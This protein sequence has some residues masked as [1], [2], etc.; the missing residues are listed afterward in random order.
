[1]DT[2]IN[3]LNELKEISPY[4]AGIERRNVYVVPIGYFDGL[5]EAIT[6]SVIGLEDS[7]SVSNQNA[8]TVPEGYFENLADNILNKIKQQQPANA[9][10]ELKAISPLLGSIAKTNVYTVPEGYFNK[11]ASLTIAQ[12]KNAVDEIKAL[13]PMLYSIQNENVYTI[14]ADYFDHFATKALAN[15]QPQPAKVVTM[16]KRTAWMKYAV[17]AAFTGM[18]AFGAFKFVDNADK[19]AT[20]DNKLATT[21]KAADEINKNGTFDKEMN[22]LSDDVIAKYLEQNGQDVDAS[23]VASLVDEK[24]LPEQEDY[25]LDDNTLDNFL[26]NVNTTDL[27]N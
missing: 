23:L 7:F 27:N 16:Q 15:V 6:A 25:L 13:S 18:V 1:M 26:N 14:P 20:I 24:E 2:R 22:N 11:L 3:I 8:F 21:M 12:N 19:P 5:A 4:L 17:A 10:E 9:S